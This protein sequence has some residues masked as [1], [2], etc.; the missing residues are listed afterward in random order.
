VP[1]Y[2][3]DAALVWQ[4]RGWA[5]SAEVHPASPT[6]PEGEAELL[7]TLLDRLDAVLAS[8]EAGP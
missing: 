3:H 5:A 7:A 6:R 1:A 8:V 2:R 4:A